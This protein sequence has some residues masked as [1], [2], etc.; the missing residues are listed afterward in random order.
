MKTCPHRRR[1]RRDDGLFAR[2]KI[3]GKRG[4]CQRRQRHR[5]EKL[6]FH[7][8]PKLSFGIK[9]VFCVG[10]FGMNDSRSIASAPERQ[11]KF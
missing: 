6:L 2:R 10:N 1:R 9:G 4:A 3:G 5:G 8:M 7:F 11:S